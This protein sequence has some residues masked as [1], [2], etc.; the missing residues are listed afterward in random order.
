M[1]LRSLGGLSFQ[2]QILQSLKTKALH[3]LH[4]TR[5]TGKIEEQSRICVVDEAELRT[6]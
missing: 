5:A 3:R 4:P 1:H 6:S 2:L